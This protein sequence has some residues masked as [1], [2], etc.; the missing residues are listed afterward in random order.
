MTR[1]RLAEAAGLCLLAAGCAGHTTRPT[2]Q[3][4]PTAAARPPHLFDGC[5]ISRENASGFEVD[6]GPVSA[7]VTAFKDKKTPAAFID[8]TMHDMGKQVD[9]PFRFD[10]RKVPTPLA[11]AT[12]Q[13]THFAVVDQQHPD[14]PA[15][16]GR[17]AAWDLGSGQMRL[18]ACRDRKP[19]KQDRCAALVDWIAAHPVA[20]KDLPRTQ[21]TPPARA[22]AD[23]GPPWPPA[24]ALHPPAGCQAK[25][26]GSKGVTLDCGDTQIILWRI[27]AS[28]GAPARAHAQAMQQAIA[29]KTL[30]AMRRTVSPKAARTQVPCR[31]GADDG[32]CDRI[33]VSAGKGSGQTVLGIGR[34]FGGLT[35]VECIFPGDANAVTPACARFLQRPSA[36]K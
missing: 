20:P 22:A 2:P 18:V 11:G 23:P 25:H 29:G 16:R 36:G 14:T 15:F 32:R 33:A 9:P 17:M 27:S 12:R 31:V 28:T 19:G 35:L 34:L 10:R 24:D 30:G 7:M 4:R 8:A 3:A 1:L 6:C 26:H 21:T 5:G 13:V